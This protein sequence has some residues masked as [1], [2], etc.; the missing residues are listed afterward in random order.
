MGLQVVKKLLSQPIFKKSENIFKNFSSAFTS[1]AEQL[2]KN[3]SFSRPTILGATKSYSREKIEDAPL[4]APGLPRDRDLRTV[5][6]NYVQR[7][8]LSAPA[9]RCARAGRDDQR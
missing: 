5:D 6:F 3:L 7:I 9:C 1:S 4:W 8:R 2:T